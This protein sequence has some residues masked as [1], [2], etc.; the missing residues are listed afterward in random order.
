[1]QHVQQAPRCRD[2]FMGS[3]FF[4]DR[5]PNFLKFGAGY[6]IGPH[7]PFRFG[8]VNRMPPHSWTRPSFVTGEGV[9]RASGSPAA[10]ANM[11]NQQVFSRTDRRG[12]HGRA[13]GFETVAR[14]RERPSSMRVFPQGRFS[15][16]RGRLAID[17]RS[18]E[19]RAPGHSS[20]SDARTVRGIACRPDLPSGELAADAHFNDL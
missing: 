11:V 4:S 17:A 7:S 20:A 12:S 3:L 2:L 15:R 14:F 19:R 18:I 6:V 8:V 5:V 9:T 1:V 10:A 13:L 16:S